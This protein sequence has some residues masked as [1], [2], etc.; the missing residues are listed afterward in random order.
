METGNCD[1][2]ILLLIP[3]HVKSG[4]DCGV[5]LVTLDGGNNGTDEVRLPFESV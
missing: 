2:T 4:M 5:A 1:K 3:V